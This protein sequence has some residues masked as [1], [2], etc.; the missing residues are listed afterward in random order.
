MLK[1]VDEYGESDNSYIEAGGYD[2]I[3]LLVHDFYINMTMFSEA[4][5][6]RGMHPPDLAES[7]KKLVYFLCEWLGGDQL[8]SEHYGDINIPR[9]H[10]GLNI[11]SAERD[12][13][14]YCMKKAINGQQYKES[15]KEYLFAQ[16]KI[17][18]DRIKQRCTKKILIS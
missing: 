6:I 8:Y 16:L 13:W 3:S 14:L 17:P 18:A 15:F 11:G 1:N 5:K 2:G 7:R 4:K 9:V 10:S 12:A